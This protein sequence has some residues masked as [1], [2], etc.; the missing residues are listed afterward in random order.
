MFS[1]Q[2]KFVHGLSEVAYSGGDCEI[3]AIHHPELLRPG[4]NVD[5]RLVR[6]GDVEQSVALR[7]S[8]TKAL[9]DRN[10]DVSA[11]HHFGEGGVDPQSQVADVVGMA[12]VEQILA[13]E[14]DGRWQVMF[15]GEAAHS[16]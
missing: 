3:S 11:F 6:A 5:K 1:A 12:V 10:Q 2:P 13:A 15:L 8:V 9:A 16:R 4:V 14:P 7:G